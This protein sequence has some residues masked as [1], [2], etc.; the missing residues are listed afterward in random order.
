MGRIFKPFYTKADTSVD[1]NGTLRCRVT[2]QCWYCEYVDA[3]GKQR[4]KKAY[5]DKAASLQL[6]AKLERQSARTREGL[7]LGHNHANKPLAELQQEYLDGLEL[8][9]CT[10][11]YLVLMKQYLDAVLPG[12]RFHT[13]HDFDAERLMQWL[14]GRKMGG[15][16]KGKYLKPSPT[17]LNNY[18]KKVKGFAKWC[19]KKTG[20][21]ID[22][23]EAKL[24][25][26][27][28]DKRRSKRILTEV[29]FAQLL[30][31]AERCPR[32]RGTV[33]SGIDRAMLYRVAA[34]TGLRASELASLVPR[35]FSLESTTPHVTIAAE[36]AKSKREER[37]PLPKK[38]L[39]EL[40]PWL[41]GRAATERL[42]PGNWAKKRQQCDWLARDVKRAKI[43]E[44][45]DRGR[46]ITLHSL[47]RRYITGLIRSG[48]DIAQV[49]RLSR[50][51]DFKTTLEYYEESSLK[52]L[53]D[54]VNRLDP[55]K[56]QHG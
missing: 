32:R 24:L 46:K 13:V 52:E 25:A 28:A 7:E 37:I 18:L 17:T 44:R 45:D 36:F 38:L 55:P 1:P 4:R 50:H 6:L 11:E 3:N 56:P 15:A 9:G 30:A 48:A 47:R 22:L 5:K 16:A 26:E 12:C 43:A 20:V 14:Q 31:A 23:S 51:K 29:E 35:S 49:T 42:W 19:Q 41:K 10:P 53:G 33:I 21:L 40:R 34:Y 8:R 27:E 54:V 39:D 2:V